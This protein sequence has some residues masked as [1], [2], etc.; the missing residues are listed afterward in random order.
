VLTGFLAPC[1][2]DPTAWCL[3]DAQL[4]FGADADLSQPQQDYDADGVAEPVADELAGLAGVRVTITIDRRHLVLDI[5]GLPYAVIKADQAPGPTT[6]GPTTG[7]TTEPGAT[8]PAPTD[9]TLTGPTTDPTAPEPTGA[10][11]AESAQTGT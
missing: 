7:P 4:G 6:P 3:G 2:K 11:T 8:D 10:P 5:Q 9:P 1:D